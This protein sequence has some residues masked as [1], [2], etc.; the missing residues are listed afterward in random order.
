MAY[1]FSRKGCFKCGNRTCFP[2]SPNSREADPKGLPVQLVT[3]LKTAPL[4]NVYVTTV[5]SLG[6]N[7]L[8]ALLLARSPLSSAILAV[9]LAISKVELIALLLFL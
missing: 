2:I 5:V 3:L 1:Q 8:L 4:S 7:P 9:E 6:M